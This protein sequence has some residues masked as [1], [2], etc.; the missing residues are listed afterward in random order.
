[1][2]LRI[3]EVYQGKT[4]DILGKRKRKKEEKEEDFS[5]K[6]NPTQN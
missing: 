6:H 3:C 2:N 4:I 1:M 5:G